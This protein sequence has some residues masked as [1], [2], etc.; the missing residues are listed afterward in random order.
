[1][2]GA[3][4]AREQ[5]ND[6]VAPALEHVRGLQEH[7]LAHRGR[8]RRP[9]G[10]SGSCRLDRAARVVARAGRNARHGVAGEGIRVVER[11]TLDRVHPLAAH[12]LAALADLGLDCAHGFS[13]P[14]SARAA[15]SSRP[16]P[17][18]PKRNATACPLVKTLFYYSD[19]L[20]YC[21][22]VISAGAAPPD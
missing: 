8:R 20:T 22:D 16:R 15:R 13:S 5:G 11:P 2:C 3:G 14:L 17:L 6:L 7:V 18:R 1:E 12:E 19:L 21:E 4:L 10:K 9:R